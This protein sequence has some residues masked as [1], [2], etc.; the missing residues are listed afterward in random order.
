[1]LSK[2]QGNG[3]NEVVSAYIFYRANQVLNIA[4]RIAELKFRKKVLY[5]DTDSLFIQLNDSDT[6]STVAEGI[7]NAIKALLGNTFNLKLEGVHKIFAVYSKKNYIV[8]TSNEDNEDIVVKGIHRFPMPV[9]VKE[10]FSELVRK[11]LSGIDP[12]TAIIEVLRSARRIDDLFVNTVKRIEELTTHSK[13]YKKKGKNTKKL[14]KES[15][16]PSTR[17]LLLSYLVFDVG[18]VPGRSEDIFAKQYS[19]RIII[20]EAVVESGRVL[21]SQWLKKQ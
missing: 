2:R 7:N 3:V 8:I 17:A 19:T 21:S 16:H 11:V 5:G 6:P 18:V 9:I 10:K 13:S 12:R 14:F 1:V 15:T 4:Q 20:D